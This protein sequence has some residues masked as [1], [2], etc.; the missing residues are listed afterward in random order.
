MKG[1]GG[2]GGLS[3]TG[4]WRWRGLVI[5]VLFLVILSM[6]VHLAFLLGVRN[7][8]HSPNP[9]GYVPVQ[10]TSVS[11][12][13]SVHINEIVAKLAPKLSKDV[14]RKS[15]AGTENQT[16]DRNVM[17]SGQHKEALPVEPHTV[18]PPPPNTIDTSYAA[19]IEGT[20][21][22]GGI[23][24]NENCDLKFGSYCLWRKE[25]REDMKDSMVKKLKDQ[26]FVARAYYPSIAKLPSQSRLT[27]ELRQNIQE[28]E[29]VL[30]ESATDANLPQEI[31]E[32]SQKT[33][34]AIVRA[35]SFPVDCNNIDRKLRQIFDLTEGEASFHMKQN[36]FLYRLAVQTMPKSLHCLSMKL[37]VEY[38]K[39]PYLDLERSQADK[40]S[41]PLLHH[42]VI[43]SNNVLASSVVINS[44]VM[45][46]KESESQVF[47]VLTDEQNYFAMKLWFFRNAFK[48]ATVQVLNIEKFSLDYYDK[49]TLSHL[50][51][52]VEFRVSFRNVDDSS[53]QERTQYLSVFS[54]VHYL[55]PEI[56]QS[57]EK[58]VVL[59]DDVVVQKDLSVLWNLD[60]G[61]KVNGAVQFCSVTLGLLKSYLGEKNFNKNSC[62]WM[63]G[64]NLVD[65]ARWRELDLT[66]T[67]RKM[68]REQV[69]LEEESIEAAALP[70][71]LLTFQD[72]IYALD[73]VGALSGLGHDYGLDVQTIKQAAVLHYNGNMK[74]WL[75]LGIPRYKQYWKKFLNPEDQFLSECNVHA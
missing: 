28:L 40:Y 25:H 14:L 33:E 31:G 35:K 48:E 8:F 51:L 10:H 39:S 42:Y 58:V 75:E 36:A 59:D 72:L 71:S 69:S 68:A 18:L 20:D 41:D 37:T 70:A 3:V 46:S 74:P 24:E 23:N 32:K 21:V 49:A 53:T 7:G 73:G 13:R 15:T 5:G 4:K 65:L 27:R 34:A 57:L 38:F 60:M 30:S 22:K 9:N 62:A 6:L 67:Y 54:D 17:Q 1:G 66:K 26:L 45:H 43:F 19:K 44:T 52:P 11:N 16:T 12:D 47:H 64:L 2:G 55:L 50:L 61:G 63:S 56:F 29:R